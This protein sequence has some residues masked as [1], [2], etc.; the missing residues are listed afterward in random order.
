ML[1]WLCT[2]VLLA[3][4]PAAGSP[5]S[6]QS[7]ARVAMQSL[8]DPG[9]RPAR[10]GEPFQLPSTYSLS[11]DPGFT[12]WTTFLSLGDE[13]VG[14]WTL[15][16]TSLG[17]GLRCGDVRERWCEALGEG[18]VALAWEPDAAPIGLF[19]GASL[20]EIA[21]ERGDLELAP[22]FIAGL[23]FRPASLASLVRRVRAYAED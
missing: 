7:A 20:V 10:R 15:E 21:D 11:R 3:P 13:G 16:G 14:Q 12:P 17:G 19:A 22:G 23:R 9:A 6:P 2:V 8:P 18:I 1:G 5:P 4:A